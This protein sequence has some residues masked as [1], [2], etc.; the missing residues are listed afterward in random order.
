M[1][2]GPGGDPVFSDSI[3]KLEPSDDIS[4]ELISIELSPSCLGALAEFED[5]RQHGVTRET[6]KTLGRSEPH[7]RGG[8]FDRVGGS[9]VG[10]VLGREV[11]GREQ[12]GPI[13]G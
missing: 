2:E 5:H 12:F 6:A 3:D 4:E 1:F 13:L 8:G 10:P 7:C 11:V 9:Q